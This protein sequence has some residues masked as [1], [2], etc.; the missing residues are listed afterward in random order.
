MTERRGYD[1]KTKTVVLAALLAGQDI[2][3]ISK[4]YKI[5]SSTIR[6]WKSAAKMSDA[7]EQETKYRV[8]DLLVRYLEK[9]LNAAAVQADHFANTDWL[10]SQNAADLAVLHGILVDKAVRIIEA[11]AAG[12]NE[13]GGE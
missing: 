10:D 5:P 3:T 9:S 4:K 7:I 12:S 6:N 2:S 1:E 11:L 8:G 13:T